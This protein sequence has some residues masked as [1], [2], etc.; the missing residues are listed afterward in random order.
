M[1]ARNLIFTGFVFAAASGFAQSI[2]SSIHV[3]QFPGST[4]A[5]KLTNAMAT[6]PMYVPVSSILV[7]DPSLAPMT[8]GTFPSLCSHCY[9]S[10][11][12]TSP[13]MRAC[14]LTLVL[15]HQAA[16]AG[17]WSAGNLE[18]CESCQRRHL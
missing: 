11:Y 18:S 1:K 13:P 4:V 12:S 5:A 14:V 16:L 3:N 17:E 10:D 8:N 6:C 7:L 2:D 9:L 15:L